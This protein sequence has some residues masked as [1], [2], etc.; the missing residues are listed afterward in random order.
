MVIVRSSL[1]RWENS[2]V[3]FF[4]EIIFAIVLSVIKIYALLL[5]LQASPVK[6]DS[7][8]RST[9]RLICR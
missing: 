6:Y 4:F 2:K 1:E 9:K 5:C 7:A 3:D 8:P